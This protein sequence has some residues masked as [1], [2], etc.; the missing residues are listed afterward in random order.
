MDFLELVKNRQSDRGYLDKPVDKEVIMHCL[1]AARLAPSA[2]NAQPWH[3]VVVTDQE[4]KNKLADCTSNKVL[5]MNH[6]TK[7][8]PV[9]IAVVEESANFTSTAGSVIKKRHFPLTDIGIA[10]EHFCLQAASE[11]L[12]TCILGWFD[13]KKAKKLLDVPKNKRL[14]LIITL[15]YS[16]QETREKRRKSLED[17]TSFNSYKAQ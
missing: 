4:V 3:F 6:F 17:I 5:G 1:E 8:A 15:G 7:Q 11:G 14:Q 13:E 9:H 16:A 10:V 12:G 2:C